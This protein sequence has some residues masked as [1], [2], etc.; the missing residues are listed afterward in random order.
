[1]DNLGINY[2]FNESHTRD[3]I[4]IPSNSSQ[5]TSTFNQLEVI[6]RL[7]NLEVNVQVSPEVNKQSSLEVNNT[8]KNRFGSWT[9]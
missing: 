8:L 7:E 3:S 4:W 5:K 1:M 6:T 2:Y 9:S